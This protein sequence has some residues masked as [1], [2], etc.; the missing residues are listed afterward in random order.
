MKTKHVTED[1]KTAKSF[2]QVL[3]EPSLADLQ[4]ARKLNKK[5]GSMEGILHP[6][7]E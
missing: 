3:K 2:I 4:K 6:A 5:Y 7:K 1:V